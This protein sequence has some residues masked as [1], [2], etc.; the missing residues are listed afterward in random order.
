MLCTNLTHDMGSR[1]SLS[2]SW[3][4]WRTIFVVNVL[5]ASLVTVALGREYVRQRGLRADI[6]RLQEQADAL[7]ARELEL[8]SL[9]TSLQTQ[10]FIEEEARLKL[11]LKRPG[12]EIVVVRGT[13]ATQDAAPRSPEL[14]LPSTAGE[15]ANPTK[16]WYYFFDR[17]TYERLTESTDATTRV[18]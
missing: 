15:I 6:A 4:S 8:F 2:R 10:S 16:W 17:N 18:Q 7:E 1:P 3:L 12:E 14:A 9:T 5:L 13:P 11:G